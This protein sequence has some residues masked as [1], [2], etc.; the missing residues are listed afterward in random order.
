MKGKS[1]LVSPINYY[2]YIKKRMYF[3]NTSSRE[4]H[5]YFGI[6]RIKHIS[7]PQLL[8]SFDFREGNRLFRN[9]TFHWS[10]PWLT[11]GR[12]LRLGE[13]HSNQ[14]LLRRKFRHD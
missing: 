7:S 14:L 3:F 4:R 9:R 13:S 11:V 5:L 1:I 2:I 12:K 8:F 10:D 6:S